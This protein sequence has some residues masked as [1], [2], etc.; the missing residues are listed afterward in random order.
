MFRP[1]RQSVRKTS[2]LL[3]I[4]IKQKQQQNRIY[5]S[6]ENLHIVLNGKPEDSPEGCLSVCPLRHDNGHA[7][8]WLLCW[9]PSSERENCPTVMA[10]FPVTTNPCRQWPTHLTSF[11]IPYALPVATDWRI[12][13]SH[14][15]VFTTK[16]PSHAEHKEYHF[17]SL[18]S[19]FSWRW[20]MLREV[21]AM[22]QARDLH[23]LHISPP[24]HSGQQGRR[25]IETVW[26]R[27]R[28]DR[29]HCCKKSSFPSCSP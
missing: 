12:D 13:C 24:M 8:S 20:T 26:E 10:E 3:H 22:P 5:N 4:F 16:P 6:F 1:I 2:R 21:L 19:L 14:Y 7:D 29:V 28:N 17:R 18:F 15:L 25:T 23:R 9:Q 11:C 27:G